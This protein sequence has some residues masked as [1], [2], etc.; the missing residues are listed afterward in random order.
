M[1]GACLDNARC[2]LPLTV[3]RHVNW[4]WGELSQTDPWRRLFCFQR[5]TGLLCF[6]C[7]AEFYVLQPHHC[8]QFPLVRSLEYIYPVPNLCFF[9]WSKTGCYSH[10]YRVLLLTLC[11]GISTNGS[12]YLKRR[13]KHA[14]RQW[15]VVKIV[16]M[17]VPAREAAGESDQRQ[18]TN[19]PRQSPAPRLHRDCTAPILPWVLPS[20]FHAC[21]S[22]WWG[23]PAPA[24][25]PRSSGIRWS[26]RWARGWWRNTAAAAPALPRVP[27]AAARWICGREKD[28][29]EWLRCLVIRICWKLA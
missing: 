29:G 24:S 17:G 23:P 10:R 18:T 7:S 20:P 16:S 9:L 14:K 22:H 3:C 26:P 15:R 2:C 1:T 12:L 13:L 4:S 27:L 6:L 5:L 19:P 8:S 25:C 11:C 21:P 28:D